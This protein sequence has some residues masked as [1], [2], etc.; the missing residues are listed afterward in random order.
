[1]SSADSYGAAIGGATSATYTPPAGLT[2]TTSYRRYANDGTCNTTPEVSTGTWTVTVI[3]LTAGAVGSDQT[4]CYNADPAPFTSLASAVSNNGT[5]TY[6]WQSSENATTWSSI[7]GAT[8]AT[9]DVTSSLTQTMYYRRVANASLNGV[10][11]QASTSNITVTVPASQLSAT[12][13]KTHITCFS[14]TD[15]TITVSSP[16]GGYGTYETSINNST[17]F[18]VSTSTAKVFSGLSDG[19]YTVYL[20]DK[21]QPTCVVTVGNSAGGTDVIY[22]PS[23][24]TFTT[25]VTHASCNGQA[26]GVLNVIN[27]S[28]GTHPELPTQSYKYSLKNDGNTLVRAAQT[29]TQFGSLP[30]NLYYITIIADGVTPSC[31]REIGIFQV[32]GPGAPITA[33]VAKTNITCNGSADGSIDVSNP[34]GGTSFLLPTRDYRYSIIKNGT[35]TTGPQVSGSFTGLGAG[36]Y[37]VYVT[38]LATGNSPA[39]Q[40]LVSTQI[41]HEPTIVASTTSKINISKNGLS[42]GEINFTVATGGTQ[43]DAGTRTYSYYIVKNGTTT[44]GPQGSGSFTGLGAG[45]YTT[46]VIAAASGST[47]ACTTQAAS[48]TVFEPS[49]VS[50]SVASTNVSCNGTI[51]GTISVTGATGGTHAETSSSRELRYTISRSG[52]ST[53]GP[54]VSGSFTGLQAGTYTVSVSAL[55]DGAT[56]PASVTVLNSTLEIYEPSA[57]TTTSPVTSSNPTCFGGTNG[58]IDVIGGAGGTHGGRGSRTYTYLIVKS[59]GAAIPTQTNPLFTGLS[60]GTYNVFVIADAVANNPACTTYVEQKI[61]VQPTSVTHSMV[62]NANTT[63]PYLRT[64]GT[65]TFTITAQ[66][67]TPKTH[68][69][70]STSEPHYNVTWTAKPSGVSANPV[71]VSS[72]NNS[73]VYTL[74]YTISGIDPDVVSGT[75]A[76]N[77]TDN[78]SCPSTDNGSVSVVANVYATVDL[79][80]DNI[81]G[82]NADGTGT[83]QRPLSTITRAID[84]ASA[85]ETINILQNSSGSPSPVVINEA[86]D[87]PI[88]TK[89][90]VFKRLG[91]SYDAGQPVGSRYSGLSQLTLEPT[92]TAGQAFVLGTTSASFDGFSVSSLY[93]NTSGTIQFAL[94][95]IGS[96]GTVRLLAGTWNIGNQLMISKQL[97]LTGS[98]TNLSSSSCDIAPTSALVAA[99]STKM[100][101]FSGTT[102]K[103]L[104]NLDLTVGILG[105]VTGRFHEV[106][107]PSAGDV[108]VS[109]MIY[110]YNNGTTTVRLYG[111]TNED[112][113][114]GVLSDVAKFIDDQADNS[115]SYGPGR[116]VYGNQG[117]LPI[118][119]LEIGWKAEDAGTTT[120]NA[121]IGQISP[122]I[123]T[124]QLRPGLS[125]TRPIWRNAANGM[126]GRAAL[127]FNGGQYVSASATAN[128]ISGAAKT[129]FVAFRTPSDDIATNAV[130]IL[131]KHGNHENGVSVALIGSSESSTELVRLSIYS[132]ASGGTQYART[133]EFVVNRSTDY[134][135]QIYFDG[136]SGANGNRV[137]MSLDNDGGQVGETKWLEADFNTTTL[138]TPSLSA[139]TNISLGAR[140]GSVRWSDEVP[141]TAGTATPDDFNSALTLGN[142]FG[143]SSG[144]IAEVLVYNTAAKTTRDAIYC[145]MRNKYLTTGTVSNGLERGTPNDDVIAGGDVEVSDDMDIYPNPAET[146]VSVTVLAASAG[147]LKVELVDGLGRVVSTIFDEP[148]AAKSVLPLT[149]DISNVANGMYMI[150]VTGSAGTNMSRP[151]IIRR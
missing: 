28:G 139:A 125:A 66:G 133:R 149:V 130:Q 88:I 45:T 65:L 106:P 13:V 67:G 55:A 15:G 140:N 53:V 132:K 134:V 74:V 7:S 32:D 147:R 62:D 61:L 118:T 123:G 92:F 113:S 57:V 77:I 96:G 49:V 59:G 138:A 111:I 4:I 112:K 105:G 33:S 126:G 69:S 68:S 148:V 58:T 150:H 35:T 110:R 37:D 76:V 52:G 143:G 39:C 42:D 99:G 94:D 41:V 146:E 75:Y 80:V 86:P 87:G 128:I 145:Y 136:A 5:I 107:S 137:G 47:P 127:A 81:N 72:T 78:N 119:G 108:N 60:I 27:P 3:D 141:G 20:R 64:G 129:V 63:A 115:A 83:G 2:T 46:F 82:S 71:F 6:Q 151:V 10:D 19:T 98:P 48:Q 40:A 73:G 56:N 43:A 122:I 100:M 17:W 144:R 104:R 135:G 22:R 1:R 25:S 29:S 70:P 54:Q 23:Q 44:T 36:T 97:T 109:N 116:V 93:V 11:C 50:A 12:V 34:T 85:N 16:A 84:I 117:P 26:D 31:S 90:L 95:T 121:G 8:A 21:A 79:Y 124:L 131:Y 30:A 24:L 51:D 91:Y 18:D 101:R 38:A 114:V 142:Y 103:T 9:Y 120:D 89:P 102:T 14:A